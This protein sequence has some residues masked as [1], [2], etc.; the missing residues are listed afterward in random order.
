M[1]ATLKAVLD[2]WKPWVP[3]LEPLQSAW[4][5]DESNFK[6]GKRQPPNKIPRNVA[7]QQLADAQAAAR[8]SGKRWIAE[9]TKL[10]LFPALQNQL[11]QEGVGIKEYDAFAVHQGPYPSRAASAG[12]KISAVS[13]MRGTSPVHGL[14][15]LPSSP[16]IGSK[17]SVRG[18]RSNSGRVAICSAHSEETGLPN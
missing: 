7:Q 2:A 16:E 15:R 5:A 18:V 14:V 9:E 11:I 10:E 3:Y 13:N 1:C 17:S 8:S 6:D 4:C 12:R